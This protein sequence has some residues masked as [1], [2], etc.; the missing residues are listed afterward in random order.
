MTW[1]S[2]PVSW[3]SWQAVGWGVSTHLGPSLP[4][5]RVPWFSRCPGRYRGRLPLR[6]RRRGAGVLIVAEGGDVAVVVLPG[7]CG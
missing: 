1:R 2:H 7:V 4:F 3:V 5:V 6:V